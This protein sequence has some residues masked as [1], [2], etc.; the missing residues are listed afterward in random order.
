[1]VF[2]KNIHCIGIGGIGLSALAQMLRA[3]GA[4][5]SG[6]DNT[7][8][9]WLEFLKR[10]NMEISIGHHPSHVDRQNLVIHTLAL[11]KN[12][13]ELLEAKKKGI[14]VKSYPQALG[15][16]TERCKTIAICGSHGKTTVTSMITKIFVE[17]GRDPTVIVGTQSFDLGNNN[18]RKGGGEFF[19]LEAC[20]YERAFLEYA[21]YAIVMT[22]LDHDHFDTYPTGKSY[23]EAFYEFAKK[24]QADKGGVLVGCF[25]DSRVKDLFSRLERENFPK[26]NLISY[27]L[28]NKEAD[29]T[30][31]KVSLRL[32][33]P[34]KHNL[35]NALGAYALSKTYGISPDGILKSLERYE[36]TGRRLEEK[37]IIRNVRIFDD[38]AHHPTEIE[39]TLEALR[40]RYP[41]EKLW[42]VY[43]PHQYIRTAHLLKRF[44]KAFQGADRVI[45]PNIYDARD[46]GDAKEKVS[47]DDLVRAMSRSYGRVENGHGFKKTAEALKKHWGEF[48]M[49]VTMGAGDVWRI[50]K[51]LE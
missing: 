41:S 29:F 14:F 38:Y 25:D 4:Q 9:P 30:L 11:D 24:V 2:G 43:Q 32:Q 39:A 5:I 28:E 26:H 37:G 12:H 1:M 35:Q 40:E 31:E 10:Q 22:N 13:P 50:Q 51:Y 19:I 45:I 42:I 3:E 33:I 44:G 49:L 17:N 36:G 15:E 16:L 20:E 47:V 23:R 46:F 7:S 27:A 34:G 18:F 8:T 21:P 6:C 48:D